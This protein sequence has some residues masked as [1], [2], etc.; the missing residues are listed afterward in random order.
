MYLPHL[1]QKL[2]ILNILSL[3]LYLQ[4]EETWGSESLCDLPNVHG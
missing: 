3:I 2:S 4:K 1:E